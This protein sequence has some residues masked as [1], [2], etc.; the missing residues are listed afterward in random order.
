M[1]PV[2][3]GNSTLY[4]GDCMDVMRGMADNSVDS[5]VTDPPYGLTSARPG[6][7]SAATKGAVMRGFMGLQWDGSIPSVEVWAEALR[8][9][10]PGGYLLAFAGTRT[11]H[12]MACRIEDAGFE[13][14]DMIA[15]V[16][17][18]GF[19]KHKSAL[20]P[21]LEPITMARKPANRST[22]LNIDECRIEGR[23]RVDYGLKSSTRTQGNTF[24]APSASADFDS[25][26]GRY[27]ANL[28]HDGSAEVVAMFPNSAGAGGSVPNVKVTGYG[29]GIG[30]GESD[31]L[32]GARTKVDSGSGSA[33]RFFY[34][35]KASRADR[36]EGLPVGSDPVVG[37][38]ATLRDCESADWTARNGNHHPTVKPT[39]LMRYL[40]RL[41][42]PPGGA[43]L[44][45]F[46]GSG[47][48]GKAAAIEGFGFIGIECDPEYIEIAKARITHAAEQKE[49][50]EIS[51]AQYD[52]LEALA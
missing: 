25:S 9:L 40:I 10:K 29:S 21:A 28:I 39:D 31:Y 44:D 19:P 52:L 1:S 15:W 20:K 50:A 13:I 41:V 12:R 17:G 8:V 16:Y 11:Q 47:S 7:R 30:T 27:P 48:T 45:P 22:L 36:N 33:A 5:I 3:I 6:G 24:G 26:K 23:E 18:S 14:R 46:M 35:A 37:T 34:C 42:T 4:L 2:I 32:G 38:G 51:P 49:S 43:T